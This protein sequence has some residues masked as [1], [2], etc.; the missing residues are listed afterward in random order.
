MKKTLLSI[1]AFVTV[2]CMYA[3][4]R[5]AV[6]HIDYSNTGNN[7]FNASA[8]GP[9]CKKTSGTD[10]LVYTNSSAQISTNTTYK[11]YVDN[12]STLDSGYYLGINAYGYKG[13]AEAYNITV[14]MDSA[15]MVIGT[16]SIW[17]GNYKLT[18]NKTLSIEVWNADTAHGTVLHPSA[19]LTGFPQNVLTSEMVPIRSLRMGYNNAPDTLSAVTWFHAPANVSGY[20]FVGYEMAYDFHNLNG[21][22]ICIRA[23]QQGTGSGHK[24][25]YYID[26]TGDTA[27]HVR[28]AVELASGTWLDPYWQAHLN[29]N[30]SIV[31][32]VQIR[33]ITGVTN[34][35]KNGLSFYG[36]YPNPAVNNATVRFSLEQTDDVLIQVMDMQGRILSVVKQAHLSSGMH[37]ISVTTATINPGNYIYSV[38]NGSGAA[39]A[40]KLT[41]IK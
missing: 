4:E 21:D 19:Y 11:Y 5:L 17:H 3:Q 25:F 40:A 16:I 12:A 8:S 34:I 30:Y 2:S 35:S 13:W 33:D 20:F 10:T 39:F 23:T 38:S 14:P 37:E 6:P 15:M 32:I 36:V 29:V 28:N 22:T 7:V 26:N 41:I 9:A 24:N 1:L 18:T 31:P 27:Y